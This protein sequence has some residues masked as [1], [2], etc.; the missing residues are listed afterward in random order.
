MLG[1]D[2]PNVA[3]VREELA[4]TLSERGAHA[5][6]EVLARRALASY[7]AKLAHDHPSLAG[8]HLTLGRVLA[9]AARTDEAETALLEALRRRRERLGDSDWRTAE[10]L[11]ELGACLRATRPVDAERYLS[12]AAPALAA[13]GP[14][15]PLVR[16]AARAREGSG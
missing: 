12:E 11:V 8:A 7:Q 10:V 5:E 2:H 6:A 1:E 9:A 3:A 4:L 16:R 14:D 15:H 13:L